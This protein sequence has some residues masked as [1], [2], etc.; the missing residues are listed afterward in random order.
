MTASAKIALLLLAA[1]ASRRMQGRDKL[2]EQINGES[3]LRR[4]AKSCLASKAGFVITILR[5][6]DQPR[7]D[8]LTGLDL[9]MI[10]NP[11]WQEGMAS[12]IRTGLE[13][14]PPDCDG[15]LVTLA[16][17]PD[18]SAY[19]FNKLIDVFQPDLGMICRAATQSGQPGHPVLFDKSYFA[20]LAAQTGDK[21]G[22]G[23]LATNASEVKLVKIAGNAACIDLDTPKDWY[24]YLHT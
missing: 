11:L 23:I 15:A 5:P 2:L 19:D 18:V 14:L 16:D 12:S 3:L 21:G 20:A 4:V 13:N 17:M 22:K 9:V 8:A 24:D 10:D 1:G 6:Q 7:R